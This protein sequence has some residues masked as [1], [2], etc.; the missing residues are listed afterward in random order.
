MGRRPQLRFAGAAQ[1]VRSLRNL[2]NDGCGRRFAGLDRARWQAPRIVVLLLEQDA[3][4]LIS[5]DR[6]YSR[7]K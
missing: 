1:A 2:A 7:D 3:T 4:E 6:R 5:N